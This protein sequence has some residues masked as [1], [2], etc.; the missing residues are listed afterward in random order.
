M[1]VEK[2]KQRAERFGAI[3]PVVTKV[4]MAQMKH[5]FCYLLL[6]FLHLAQKPFIHDVVIPSYIYIFFD[7]Q[8]EEKD[9]LL[10]RKQRFGVT[11]SASP[12]TDADVSFVS[13]RRLCHAIF[14]HFRELKDC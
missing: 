13:L 1:D 6:I 10:K 12:S 9:K 11:V 14:H 2:L 5:Y 7:S 8:L 4:L 3:S